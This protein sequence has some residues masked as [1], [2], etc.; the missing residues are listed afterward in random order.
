MPMR[1]ITSPMGPAKA[2]RDQLAD[3]RL[4]AG[5][6]CGQRRGGEMRLD[7]LLHVPFGQGVQLPDDVLDLRRADRALGMYLGEQ[8]HCLRLDILCAEARVVHEP[9]EELHAQQTFADAVVSIDAAGECLFR[10]V[11][12]HGPQ[13][14]SAYG[15]VKFLPSLVVS[16]LGLQVV[17]GGV[18]VARVDANPYTALVL[19][20]VDDIGQML[21][22]EPHV[23]ALTGR[24]FDDGGHPLRLVQGEVDAFGHAGEALF[25]A[26]FLQMASRVEIKHF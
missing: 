20:L 9:F 3:L 22:A 21:E 16:V 12:V 15:V 1:S 18:G 17:A 24:V 19:H 2:E 5:R 25:H 6:P 10:V 4:V 14:V 13:V 26:D 11:E 8:P 7:A 23:G